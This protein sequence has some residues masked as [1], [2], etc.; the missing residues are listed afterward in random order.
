M[1]LGC[2]RICAWTTAEQARSVMTDAA[3]ADLPHMDDSA[4][5]L[6]EKCSVIIVISKYYG[7][8]DSYQLCHRHHAS[9]LL[10]QGRHAS[11]SFSCPTS[12]AICQLLTQVC[13]WPTVCPVSATRHECRGCGG[14]LRPEALSIPVVIVMR[15]SICLTGPGRQTETLSLKHCQLQPLH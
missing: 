6:D 3:K 9:W 8:K 7:E 15:I 4:T 14:G 10:R 13:L 5:N 12:F 11:E 1:S 2:R